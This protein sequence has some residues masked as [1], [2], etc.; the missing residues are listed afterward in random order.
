MR[1]GITL[2]PFAGQYREDLADLLK[3]IRSFSV[4]RYVVYHQPIKDGIRIGRVIHGARY[5]RQMPF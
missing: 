5:V 3:D 4:G 2:N 1:S